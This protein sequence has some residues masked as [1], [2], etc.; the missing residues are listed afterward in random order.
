[1]WNKKSTEPPRM[2]MPEQE[3]QEI[4]APRSKDLDLMMGI[5]INEHNRAFEEKGCKI[6]WLQAVEH[7]FFILDSFGNSFIT[8]D[9]MNLTIFLK[10]S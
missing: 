1:M 7:L 3:F 5:V 6:E 10:I 2:V 9:G 8:M 4:L